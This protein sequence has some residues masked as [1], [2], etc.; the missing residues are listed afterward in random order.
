[1]AVA[2]IPSS[3]IME[4]ERHSF[5]GETIKILS[6]KAVFSNFPPPLNRAQHKSPP[7]TKIIIETFFLREKENLFTTITRFL[8]AASSSTREREREKKRKR[9]K[10][11]EGVPYC[12]FDSVVGRKSV[13][14]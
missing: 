4:I 5:V 10:T 9:E 8:L 3:P 7:F 6:K 11:K 14:S 2:A 13:N 12:E 1:M